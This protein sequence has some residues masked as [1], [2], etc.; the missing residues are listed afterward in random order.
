MPF[1]LGLLERVNKQFGTTVVTLVRKTKE[2][3]VPEVTS[4]VKGMFE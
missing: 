4:T 2:T 1:V 3:N